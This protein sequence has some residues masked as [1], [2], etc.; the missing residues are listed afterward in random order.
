MK[1]LATKELRRSLPL[2][3][4]LSLLSACSSDGP[5]S[6]ATA[7]LTA[8]DVA[9]SAPVAEKRSYAVVAP[10]GTRTDEYYWLRDD[11]RQ[12][13]NMLAYLKAENAYTDAAIA[14]L[15]GTRDTLYQEMV[16]RLK[17]DDATAPYLYKD[18]WYYSR[19]EAGKDYPIHARRKGS[20]DAPEEVMLDL[21]ALAQG[22]GYYSVDAFQVSPDQKRLAFVEDTVG[23]RQYRLRIKNLATGVITDTGVEGISPSLAWAADNAT[24]VYVQNDPV[25]LLGNQVKS[26]R[27]GTPAASDPLLYQETDESYYMGVGLTRSERY[28]CIFLESTLSDEQRCADASN[29]KSFQPIAERRPDFKYRADHLD[30][31]WV[32]RTNWNAANFKLMGFADGLWNA[33]TQWADLVPHDPAVLISGFQLFNNFIALDERANGLTRIRLRANTGQETLV[34]ADEPAYEMALD[35]NAQPDS[36]WVRYRYTSLTTPETIYEVH[37]TRK[38]RRLLKASPVLG[39]FDKANYATERLWATARDGTRI[40]VS[41]VYRKGFVKNG[42]AALLQYGYGSYGFSMEPWFD[43]NI[44]SLLDRGMVY[45]VA[46]VRGGQEMGRQW[47]EDGK[48]LN[49][50]NTFTDFI[51]VTQHLVRLGYAAPDRVAA[52]GGSAG[53]LLM[54]AV[55]NMAPSSYRAIVSQVPFVDIVTT[56]LDETIPLTTNE[57]DE[58]GNPKDPVFYDYMLSYSPYDQLRATAYPAMYIG[59]GLWDSQVQYWEPAKYVARLRARR[60]D[61]RLLLLRTQMDAGHGGSSARFQRYLDAAEYYAFLLN[62]LGVPNERIR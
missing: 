25:T 40:P 24:V 56:M 51:D 33:R 2:L 41:V 49:K 23:R 46:H 52:M 30:G 31:R 12:D 18:Y 37:S 43:A 13:A 20:L 61:N 21:N 59:T 42:T 8:A 9:Q 4:S 57:F 16:G 7:P 58:W 38:E 11:T 34:A 22:H 10:G 27:I 1:P 26:H 53:G 36:D 44:L 28:L 6:A 14:L 47:Y 5:D 35:T 29:P 3:L 55:A 60:T 32:V 15:A 62:Q 48:L 50:K 54:G 39:G 19:Y 45:A 17:Q